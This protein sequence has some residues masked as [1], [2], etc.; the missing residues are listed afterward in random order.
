MDLGAANANTAGSSCLG[1]HS[2]VKPYNQYLPLLPQAHTGGIST[3]QYQIDPRLLEPRDS[4]ISSTAST[5]LLLSTLTATSYHGRDLSRSSSYWYNQGLAAGALARSSQRQ[6]STSFFQSTSEISSSD[7]SV[8]G[9]TFYFKD[10]EKAVEVT[11]NLSVLNKGQ[12]EWRFINKGPADFE[13]PGGHQQSP[14]PVAAFSS[15]TGLLSQYKPYSFDGP[16]NISQLLEVAGKPLPKVPAS[17]KQRLSTTDYFVGA[18]EGQITQEEGRTIYEI[19]APKSSQ[20]FIRI[21]LEQEVTLL[22][23][24]SASLLL[25]PCDYTQTS[26]YCQSSH[27]SMPKANLLIPDRATGSQAQVLGDHTMDWLQLNTAPACTSTVGTALQSTTTIY[28]STGFSSD[29][30]MADLLTQ[31]K[32]PIATPEY[33]STI[34]SLPLS[35]IQLDTNTNCPS[36]L[37]SRINFTTNKFDVTK[38][39][40]KVPTGTQ[41]KCHQTYKPASPQTPYTTEILQCNRYIPEEVLAMTPQFNPATLSFKQQQQGL[42]KVDNNQAPVTDILKVNSVQA[43]TPTQVTTGTGRSVS[44]SDSCKRKLIS[45]DSN[46]SS[47]PPAAKRAQLMP[48]DTWAKTLLIV[49]PVSVGSDLASNSDNSECVTSA[50]LMESTETLHSYYPSMDSVNVPLPPQPQPFSKASMPARPPSAQN[51]VPFKTSVSLPLHHFTDPVLL[52]RNLNILFRLVSVQDGILKKFNEYQ[53]KYG[54]SLYAFYMCGGQSPLLIPDLKTLVTEQDNTDM[55][56]HGKSLLNV[57][58][59]IFGTL[60]KVILNMTPAQV[61]PHFEA[62]MYFYNFAHQGTP[63]LA[64]EIIANTRLLVSLLL[65]DKDGL[66]VI[67]KVKAGTTAANAVTLD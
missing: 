54:T 3:S 41:N 46:S 56:L 33:S 5:P 60:M 6:Q 4:F 39:S 8:A 66:A 11:G 10:P 49:A 52:T 38:D 43:V 37:T 21:P 14:T 55:Q 27:S 7:T 59:S 26:A 16:P 50:L 61:E 67:E 15:I 19:S 51:V 17:S 22:N 45:Y 44:G 20:S 57:T 18:S 53:E 2:D 63:L 31:Q 65:D 42:T 25:A 12:K 13:I 1:G 47:S 36:E 28:P 48:K 30:W 9:S 35:S 62:L 29:N 23:I 64:V 32:L 24:Q 34:T 40:L 58:H